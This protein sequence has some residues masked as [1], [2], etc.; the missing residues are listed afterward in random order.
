MR[1]FPEFLLHGISSRID[2]EIPT[3]VITVISTRALPRISERVF[4]E[5]S[6]GAPP[7]TSTEESPVNL[8]RNYREISSGISYLGFLHLR[9]MFHQISEFLPGLP[10]EDNFRCFPWDVSQSLPEFILDF[11]LSIFPECLLRNMTPTYC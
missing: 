9:G 5:F 11:L 2:P 4:R 7:G 10:S 6:A 1:F 3:I 8:S